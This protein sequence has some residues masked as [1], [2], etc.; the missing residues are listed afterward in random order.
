MEMYEGSVG[1]GGVLILNNTPDPTGLIPSLDVARAKE[2]G[3]EIQRRYGVPIVYSQGKGETLEAMPSAPAT[4]DAAIIM[5]DISQGE[6]IR[7]YVLEGLVDGAWVPLSKG[8]AVGHKKIDK[9]DPVKVS[10]V[11]I[12]VLRSVGE[13]QIRKL[14]VFNTAP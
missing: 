4:I 13:P 2:F 12:R 5:E 7:E 3:A 10:K 9:F 11:R 6:R 1:H 14:A 8:T